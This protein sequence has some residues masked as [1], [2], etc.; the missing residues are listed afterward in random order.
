MNK[1]SH[2]TWALHTERRFKRARESWGAEPILNILSEI[3]DCARVLPPIEASYVRARAVV[4]LA[5]Q[6]RVWDR[7]RWF[8]TSI[9]RLFASMRR[10]TGERR[11]GS[12]A[13]RK[14]VLTYGE[15]DVR[16]PFWKRGDRATD[17]L[18]AAWAAWRRIETID[19]WRDTVVSMVP[20]ADRPV[21]RLHRGPDSGTR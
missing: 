1:S 11:R 19:E 9:M 4:T 12:L 17:M 14:M 8:E 18:R 2:S 15:E 7:I 16:G 20:E 21:R 13:N 5:V 10:Y 3:D 6:A